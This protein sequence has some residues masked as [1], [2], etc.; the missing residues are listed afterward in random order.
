M[1]YKGR[2]EDQLRLDLTEPFYLCRAEATKWERYFS[3]YYHQA[4][5]GFRHNEIGSLLPAGET[6]FWLKKDQTIQGGIA[7]SSRALRYLFTIPPF[8]ADPEMVRMIAKAL[9]QIGGM[10][11]PFRALTI[12]DDDVDV[13]IRAG[14]RPDSGRFRWMQ[15]PTSECSNVSSKHLT[16]RPAEII[17]EAGEPHLKL[18][19]EAGLF[20]FK[21]AS[22]SG[23]VKPPSSTFRQMLHRL[24]EYAAHSPKGVLEASSFV[25]D[26]ATH[27]LIGVCLIGSRGGFPTID[28]LA[29]LP[30]F[31]GRGVATS[32]LQR[33]LTVLAQNG[34]PLI[35]ICIMHGHSLESLCYRL[36][37]M[38]GP[39]F[40]QGMTFDR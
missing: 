34:E 21:H 16:W 1:D 36:G 5:I 28:E 17:C 10:E 30:A 20:L 19:R 33:A 40:L 4:M 32:M 39:P 3:V 31:K 11:Q 13:Y 7:L 18:E 22:E 6:P 37:F 27:A 38:P 14:F 23:N 29:V 9:Q 8:K 26:D 24:R 2:P 15:R 25:F 35:R 12:P